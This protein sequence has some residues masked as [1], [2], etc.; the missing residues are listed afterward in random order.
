MTTAYKKVAPTE[1]SRSTL[2]YPLLVDKKQNHMVVGFDDRIVVTDDNLIAARDGADGRARRQT[3]FLNPPADDFRGFVV[4]M[5]DGF[6]RL[7]RAAPQ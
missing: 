3:D 4:A 5:R 1:K 6:N 2:R 7:S